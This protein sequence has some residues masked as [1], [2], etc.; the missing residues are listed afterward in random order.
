MANKTVAERNETGEKNNAY[1]VY[2]NLN[3]THIYIN[4]HTLSLIGTKLLSQER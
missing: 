1:N 4:I 3:E 2:A